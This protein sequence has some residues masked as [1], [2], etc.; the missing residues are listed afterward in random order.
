[1]TMRPRPT[2]KLVKTHVSCDCP[3]C[4]QVPTANKQWGYDE[5][6]V[7]ETECI[8]CGE[9]IGSEPYE[10]ETVWARFGQMLFRHKRCQEK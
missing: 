1:M 10:L 7:P 8:T 9:K 4:R 2:P 3:R 5:A 6:E